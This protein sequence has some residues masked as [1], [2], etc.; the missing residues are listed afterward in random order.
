MVGPM[1]NR[2]GTRLAHATDPEIEY[3]A[4][5]PSLCRPGDHVVL[6]EGVRMPLVLRQMEWTS[7]V[8]HGTVETWELLGDCYVHG[9]MDGET[10]RVD[11][12]DNE[13]RFWWIA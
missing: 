1:L 6:V 12:V 7:V 4:L 8:G 11:K 2:R 5:V 9:V 3:L 10:W 13:E